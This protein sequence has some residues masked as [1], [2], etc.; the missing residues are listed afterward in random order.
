MAQEEEEQ[1]DFGNQEGEEQDGAES[2][3]Q[4]QGQQPADQALKDAH[5]Q[6]QS[7]HD[8]NYLW[9]KQLQVNDL[10]QFSSET[11]VSSNPGRSQQQP[12]HAVLQAP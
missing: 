11:M 1:I 12:V 3:A 2:V 4:Q 6:E 9:F 8:A 10:D 5:H 7:R